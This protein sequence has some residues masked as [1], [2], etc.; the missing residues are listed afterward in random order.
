MFIKEH[1]LKFSNI[2]K[3]LLLPS[4]KLLLAVSRLWNTTYS[5]LISALE[6]KE[7]FPSYRDRIP[8]YCWL[9]TSEDWERVEGACQIRKV[10]NDV[11]SAF[12]CCKCP[13]ANTF[14]IDILG[15]ID[16]SNKKSTYDNASVQAMALKIKGKFDKYWGEC[17]LL[18][19]VAAVFDPRFKLDL[20]ELVF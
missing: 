19:S 18:M 16:I 3:Q 11:I 7:V 5:M 10:F 1:L 17:N 2:A 8:D 4:K 15:I 9:P 14:L 12:L 13:T 6:F 20:I